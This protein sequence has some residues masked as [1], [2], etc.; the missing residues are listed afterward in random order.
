MFIHGNIMKGNMLWYTDTWC[1]DC[2]SKIDVIKKWKQ[3]VV[4]KNE[5]C[6]YN[7]FPWKE[8]NDDLMLQWTV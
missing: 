6:D 8:K 7:C 1:T 2:L 4:F 5:Y 3:V